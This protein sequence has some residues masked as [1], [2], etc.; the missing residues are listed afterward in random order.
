MLMIIGT[1]YTSLFLA[2]E[3][4]ALK[5]QLEYFYSP[6]CSHCEAIEKEIIP[7]VMEK[8][9]IKIVSHDISTEEGYG[10][11]CELEKKYGTYA[12]IFPVVLV[13]DELLVG[14]KEIRKRLERKVQDF[15]LLVSRGRAGISVV[16]IVKALIVI[17]IIGGVIIYVSIRTS[18]AARTDNNR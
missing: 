1:L 5:L 7:K 9:D 6:D 3:H 18:K 11:L 12:D 16:V 8:F 17:I 10:R 2:V 15:G 13:G 4:S 14:E